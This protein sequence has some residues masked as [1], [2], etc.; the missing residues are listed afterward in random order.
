MEPNL[1]RT[2]GVAV[3][4]EVD[5]PDFDARAEV[6]SGHH[7]RVESAQIPE[8]AAAILGAVQTIM[9]EAVAEGA[10]CILAVAG[11]E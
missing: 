1:R 8:A 9:A 7:K 11:S 4:I 10:A 2:R 3:D 5:R 6:A